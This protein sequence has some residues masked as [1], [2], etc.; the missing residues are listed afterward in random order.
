VIEYQELVRGLINMMVSGLGMRPKF[1]KGERFFP[2]FS[3]GMPSHVA[4]P[5]QAMRMR[6]RGRMEREGKKSSSIS[7]CLPN[8]L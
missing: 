7:H 4:T 2:A 8:I 5:L 3:H 6:K 1:N